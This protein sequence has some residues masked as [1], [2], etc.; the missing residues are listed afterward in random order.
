MLAALT[1]L[2]LACGAVLAAD[3]GGAVA[4]IASAA[5]SST[6]TAAPAPAAT[7]VRVLTFAKMSGLKTVPLRTSDGVAAVDFGIRRDELVTQA[8]LKLRYT[9]S[10][11]LIP[12]QSHIKLSL[13][14]ELIGVVPI[15]R[16]DAGKKLLFEADIDPRLL[17]GFNKLGMNFIG[18]YTNECEDPIHSSLW[19]D[20]SGSSEL[21]LSIQKLTVASDLATLPEPFFDQHDNRRLNLN[22]IFAGKPSNTTLQAAAVTASWFGKLAAWRGAR[23]PSSF[24]RIPPG[25]GIVIAPNDERPA[26]L[27]GLP[28]ATGPVIMVMTNPV[29]ISS[30]LLVLSGRNGDDIRRAAIALTQ[31]NLAMSGTQVAIEEGIPAPVRAA[32]D[33]PNWVRLDRPMQFAELV[34]SPLGLQVKGHEPAP[35]TINLRIPPDLFTWR[36]KGVPLDLKYRYSPPSRASES[37]LTMRIN[38]EL[39]QAFNLISGSTSEQTRVRLPVLDNGLQAAS[40]TVLI[41]AFK[42]GIR[43][44]LQYGFS[45]TYL[46][47]G[48]CRDGQVD[49]ISSMIDA[50]SRIDFSGLPNYAEMP[51]LGFFVSSGF[52]FTKYADLAQTVVVLPEKPSGQDI[53]TMLGL[54]GRMGESTGVAA[55][56]VRVAGPLDEAQ[57]KDADLLV[58]GASQPLLRKWASQ[59]PAGVLG[60]MKRVSQAARPMGFLFDWMGLNAKLDPE[61]ASQ[62]NLEGSG[63]LALMLGFESPL[64]PERSVVAVTASATGQMLSALDALDDPVRSLAIRGSAA[65]IRGEQVDSVLAGRTYTVGTLPFWTGIWYALSGH[66]LLLALAAAVVVLIFGFALWRGL[67]AVA[68]RRGNGA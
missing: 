33:A 31:G 54:M 18:H 50:D 16:E 15:T 27:A 26:G 64:T 6:T 41:P 59:L 39:V 4:G 36:N 5:A 3:D 20:L 1:A 35:I 14:G 40:Q 65:F 22:Y 30:K 34:D 42:L 29:D 10:P 47:E 63:P 38:N 51:N 17:T 48:N 23:F 66:P 24:N 62:E 13:N 56:R 67:R 12:T 58:I 9:Y 55:T 11:A 45:Y 49:D 2:W 52:P 37:R 19:A 68:Q 25:H 53:E 28:P 21:I 7:E 61:V 44:A 8:H 57:L 46:K 43:N 60:N 32:Y